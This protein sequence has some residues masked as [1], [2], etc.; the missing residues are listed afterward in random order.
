MRA[1]LALRDFYFSINVIRYLDSIQSVS[2]T[3]YSDTTNWRRTKK[4]RVKNVTV[5]TESIV[6][7]LQQARTFC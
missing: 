1:T 4:P 2:F 7:G 5:L 3:R 6:T